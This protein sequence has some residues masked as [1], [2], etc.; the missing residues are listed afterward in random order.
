[1]FM[2]KILIVVLLAEK[3]MNIILLFSEILGFLIIKRL[4]GITERDTERVLLD[5]NI[6]HLSRAN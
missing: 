2:I 5:I 4:I 1:M 3:K 6:N